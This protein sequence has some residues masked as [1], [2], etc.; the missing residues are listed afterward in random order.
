MKENRLREQRAKRRVA[1]IALAVRDIRFVNTELS[2][3]NR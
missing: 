2:L 1:I 3:E